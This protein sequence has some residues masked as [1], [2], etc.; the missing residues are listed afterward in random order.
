MVSLPKPHQG[1]INA[2][3]PLEHWRQ[4]DSSNN[5]AR[6]INVR[7]TH[8]SLPASHVWVS[9]RADKVSNITI[10][11][12]IGR[13]DPVRHRRRVDAAVDMSGAKSIVHPPQKK[14]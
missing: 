13:F 10:R 7:P 4:E 8:S 6:K 9:Q 3:G 12:A 11:W 14:R 5:T 2:D 1:Q